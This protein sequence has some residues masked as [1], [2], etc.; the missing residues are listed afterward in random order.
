MIKLRVL[1]I[2]RVL[3]IDIHLGSVDGTRA[4]DCRGGIR[5][6]SLS[7]SLFVV[8]PLICYYYIDLR[9]GERS[10]F[11]TVRRSIGD[12]ERFEDAISNGTDAL[13]WVFSLIGLWLMW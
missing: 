13:G 9:L 10:T 2:G 12:T 3:W 7:F 6:H 8:S 1:F 5:G 11:S 4:S